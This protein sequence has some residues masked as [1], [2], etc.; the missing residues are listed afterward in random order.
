MYCLSSFG[1]RQYIHFSSVYYKYLTLKDIGFNKISKKDFA[2]EDTLYKESISNSVTNSKGE[3]AIVYTSGLFYNSSGELIYRTEDFNGFGFYADNPKA[4]PIFVRKPNNEFI[5]YCFL[6]NEIPNASS[7]NANHYF[8]DFME[9]DLK[10]NNGKGGLVKRN[11][12]FIPNFHCNIQACIIGIDSVRV[13]FIANSLINPS[14]T[15]NYQKL[16]N[17]YTVL[18][19]ENGLEPLEILN[20]PKVYTDLSIYDN[21]QYYHSFNMKYFYIKK[22]S[23]NLNTKLYNY[24]SLFIYEYNELTKQ[25]DFKFKKQLLQN[26]KKP[27]I[28][29]YASSKNGLNL[30]LY[31]END[32]STYLFSF[33]QNLNT[34][35]IKKI[36]SNKLF[37]LFHDIFGDIYLYKDTKDINFN[38]LKTYIYKLDFSNDFI[39]CNLKIVD[40]TNFILNHNKDLASLTN[41]VNNDTID[42]NYHCDSN[43]YYLTAKNGFKGP[44]LWDFGD[45]K[46]QITSSNSTKYKF[47]KNGI[48]KIK[49]ILID[50]NDTIKSYVTINNTFYNLILPTDTTIFN[51]FTFNLTKGSLINFNWENKDTIS[52]RIIDTSTNYSLKITL[53]ECEKIFQ[54][55]IN[56]LKFK[57]IKNYSCNNEKLNIQLYSNADSIKLEDDNHLLK[58]YNNN[59]IFYLNTWTKNQN[60]ARIICFLNGVQLDTV[61][62][63]NQIKIPNL[64]L[65]NDTLLCKGNKYTL[66]VNNDFSKVLWNDSTSKYSIDIKE[67]GLY[68]VKVSKSECTLSDSIFVDFLDCNYN[69]NNVCKGDVITY[70]FDKSIDSVRILLNSTNFTSKNSSID[71]LFTELGINNFKYTLFKSNL[72]KSFSLNIYVNEPII[73]LMPKDTILCN[74]ETSIFNYFRYFNINTTLPENWQKKSENIINYKISNNHCSIKDSMVIRLKICECKLNIPDAF[75]PNFNFVNDNFNIVSNCNMNFLE[76]TIYNSWGGEIFKLNNTSNILW[77]GSFNGIPCPQGNY[78]YTLKYK[79]EFSSALK[80]K[81][82]TIVLLR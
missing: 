16:G 10:L 24:D 80:I 32:T 69:F 15:T 52:K 76:F 29:R 7:Y 56:I 31:N 62:S 82:G 43:Y 21:I 50:Q 1:Q 79:D 67:K 81:S 6:A 34:I 47:F 40:S 20:L 58:L 8:V 66:N 12:Y 77:D 5:Y 17:S 64:N 54:G 2:F 33:V 28:L 26:T 55:K 42:V 72:K 44:F 48:Y 23:Y 27:Y 70:K 36:S 4:T 49:A 63:V 51:T 53:K 3:L 78:F 19:T 18:I 30:I 14:Q 46:P 60:Y 39:N 25:F 37:Y 22:Y 59:Q 35:L 74:S 68:H 57:I 61:I 9:F 71:V 38:Y 73:N 65:G 75:S 11:K 45:G 41:Y 13:N